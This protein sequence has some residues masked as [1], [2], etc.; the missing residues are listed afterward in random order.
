MAFSD[1][2]IEHNSDTTG[3]GS[4]L[5]FIAQ[6]ISQHREVLW[7]C[8]QILKNKNRTIIGFSNKYDNHWQEN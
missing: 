1:D 5:K 8:Y 4:E 7:K 2:E 6:E 3:T